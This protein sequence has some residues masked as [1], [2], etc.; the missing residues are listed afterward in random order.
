MRVQIW[1]AGAMPGNASPN[2]IESS[3]SSW[4]VGANITTKL[5]NQTGEVRTTSG[6]QFYWCLTLPITVDDTAGLGRIRTGIVVFTARPH[7]SPCRA[8]Y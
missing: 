7:G 5:I 4:G 3:Q 1:A 2:D 8:L 6:S